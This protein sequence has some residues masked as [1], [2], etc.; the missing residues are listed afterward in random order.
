VTSQLFSPTPKDQKKLSVYDGDQIS[1]E[2]AWKHYDGALGFNSVGVMAVSVGECETH[3]LPAVADPAPFP[4]HVVIDFSAFAGNQ[5]KS[6]A[7]K[8]QMAAISRGWLFQS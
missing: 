6:K 2:N 8:L 1:A 7:K 3:S 5:I 4:E